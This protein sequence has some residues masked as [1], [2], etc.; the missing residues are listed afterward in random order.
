MRFEDARC[1]RHDSVVERSWVVEVAAN[2]TL[3]HQEGVLAEDGSQEIVKTSKES[4]RN[5]KHPVENVKHEGFTEGTSSSSQRGKF[6]ASPAESSSTPT[7]CMHATKSARDT[8]S[9]CSANRGTVRAPRPPRV[10]GKESGIR[11]CAP[12]LIPTCRT[13][14]TRSPF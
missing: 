6:H 9:K 8:A 3:R 11:H 14:S 13:A 5:T 1:W 7:T 10:V 4:R 12:S 2:A